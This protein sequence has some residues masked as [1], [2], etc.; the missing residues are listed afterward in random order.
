MLHISENVSLK[1]LN[2]F[3]VEA[4]ARWLV[5]INSE[6]DL[7]E[8][9]SDGRWKGVPQ[10]IIG[11]GSNILFT[12]DFEGLV[13]RMNIKGIS[14]EV[15]GADIFVKAGG[16]EVW[17]D[18]VKYCVGNG[19]AGVENLSLIPGTVG[20]SPVQ[21]IG[22]YG[23]ELKDVFYS[24]RVF[25]VESGKIS[26]FLKDDCAFGYRDSIFKKSLKG[27]TL[28]TEVCY[29]LS[30]IPDINTSYGAINQELMNRGIE[31]PD[32]KDISDVV[33][34]IRVNK[35]PDPSTIGNAGSFFK[36]P[37]V[38]ADEFRQLQSV[39]PDIVH[40]CL[41]NSTIKLAAGWL[42]EQSGWKGK[43]IGEAGTWKNQAL[44]LVN[45]G[46]A[47]GSDI[48][49]LSERIIEDV[50]NRFGVTLE[51]EVNVI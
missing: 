5:T 28:I 20:A 36:N 6:N 51:R 19:F 39:F 26:V 42:L 24:C 14:H 3:G 9:F 25:N 15:K 12:R 43:K 1:E 8:L 41:S 13:I 31:S 50:R 4:Y 38:S 16:G 23:V 27:R 46:N 49:A 37:V 30:A 17:N 21:N 29:K 32:I 11:G 22:A 47:T 35:L 44:V 33:S 7:Q 18:L 48:Y 2:T 34:S 10:L 45:F 40:Y